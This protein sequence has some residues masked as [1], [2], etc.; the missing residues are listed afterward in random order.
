MSRRMMA[1]L[2]LAVLAVACGVQGRRAPE[3]K[4]PA[5]VNGLTGYGF[6]SEAPMQLAVTVNNDFPFGAPPTPADMVIRSGTASIQ[7]DSIEPAL[8]AVRAL[9]LRVGGYIANTQIQGGDGQLR[10]ATLEV[11]MPAAR[12][13]EAL[14]GLQPI[15]KVEAVN[16]TAE[17]V[18]EEFVDV[19]ARMENARRLERRLIGILANRTG[20]LHDVLEIEQELARV[21]E[22]IERH[23]GRLRYLRAHVATSTLAVTVH[24]HVPVVGVAGSS[25]LGDAARQGWRN[26]VALLAFS[27]QALG[28]IVPLGVLTALAWPLARRMRRAA[29]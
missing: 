4:A 26:F 3:A 5:A 6:H 2:A 28:V 19:T 29:A 25:P 21:R 14:G 16:V 22:E 12:F 1:A 20:K 7:V 13:E 24:E 10:L 23:E 9:A 15:G 11:K 18:G 8:A 17:D 27:I